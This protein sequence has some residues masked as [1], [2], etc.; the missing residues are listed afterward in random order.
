ML[1]TM[2]LSVVLMLALGLVAVACGGEP[3]PTPSGIRESIPTPAISA[4]EYRSTAI[5]LFNEMVSMVEDGV[6]SPTGP[7]LGFNR[8]NPR[9]MQWKKNVEALRDRGGTFQ[10]GLSFNEQCFTLSDAAGDFVCGTELITFISLIV[11][12]HWNEYQDLV[13]KFTKAAEKEGK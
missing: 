2:L 4:E 13:R 6:V 12:D 10:D 5:S 8:G 1:K 9:A 3:E 11:G 7:D